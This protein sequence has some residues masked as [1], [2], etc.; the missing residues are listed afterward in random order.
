MKNGDSFRALA[1]ASFLFNINFIIILNITKAITRLKTGE[2]TQMA[3][4]AASLPQLMTLKP[5]AMIPNPIIAPTIECVVETGSDFQV[6]KLT[7]KAAASSAESAPIRS[8]KGFSTVVVA[9]DTAVLLFSFD[10]LT[11]ASESTIATK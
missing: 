1:K 6:A 2:I 7:H 4:T 5:P 9:V 10:S 3:T 8:T 11:A